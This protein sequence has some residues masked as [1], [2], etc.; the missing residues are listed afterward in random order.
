MNG[1]D[2]FTE[3]FV[4]IFGGGAIIGLIYGISRRYDFTTFIK[5]LIGYG[6]LGIL[7]WC[8]LRVLPEFLEWV[9]PWSGIFIILVVLFL[10]SKL[11]RR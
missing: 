9:L 3:I 10:L 5:N 11:I 8:V 7:G 6:G 1:T 2:F 4:W